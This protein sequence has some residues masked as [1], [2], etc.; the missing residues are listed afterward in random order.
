MKKIIII[1][2][3]EKEEKRV[4]ITEEHICKNPQ[5]NVGKQNAIAYQKHHTS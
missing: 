4:G 1:K 2:R 5:Q 3:N